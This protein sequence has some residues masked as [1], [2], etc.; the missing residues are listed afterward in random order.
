MMGAP[1]DILTE[2]ARESG[3]QP[4]LG[5][6]DRRIG[7]WP[8][9]TEHQG[10]CKKLFVGAGMVRNRKDLVKGGVTHTENIKSNARHQKRPQPSSSPRNFQNFSAAD[11]S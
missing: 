7:S 11:G 9:P 2:V 4:Q 3:P 5:N 8:T 1:E 6:H 10:F